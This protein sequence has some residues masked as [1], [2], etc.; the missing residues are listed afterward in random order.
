MESPEILERADEIRGGGRSVVLEATITA[1]KSGKK[2]NQIKIEISSKYK[3][4]KT[5]IKSLYPPR[6]KGRFMLMIGDDFWIYL[7]HAKRPFRISPIQRLLGSATYAD[8]AR[9]TYS[10][11]YYVSLLK[12][13]AFKSKECYILELLAKNKKVAYHRVIYW[14][15]KETF[16]PLRADF[17]VVSGKLMKTAFF[18]N[19]KYK[20]DLKRYISTELR[21]IDHFRK[22]EETLIKYTKIKPQELAD[23]IFSREHLGKLR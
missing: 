3:E 21:I 11:D 20:E 10:G 23:K 16:R 1:F 22:D 14:V 17:F 5:L 18:E 6:D 13:K 4:R 15:E 7:S 8:I 9:P 19:Y 12:E 2:D